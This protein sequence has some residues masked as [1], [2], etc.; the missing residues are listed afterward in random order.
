MLIRCDFCD[1]KTAVLY[2]KADTAKLCLLCDQHVHKANALSLKHVRFQIC[3]NCKNEAATIQ[4]PTD[5]LMLCQECDWDIHN[6]CSTSSLHER[7]QVE[8]FSGS[9]SIIELATFFGFDLKPKDLIAMDCRP[10]LYEHKLRDDAKEQLLEMARGNL[11]K[12]DKEG[13]EL[14]PGTPP[15]RLAQQVDVDSLELN[16]GYD[17]ELLKQ[18]TPF[19]SLLMLPTDA[20]LRKTGYASEGDLLWDCNPSYQMAQVWDFQLGKS[21]HCG[22][23][24]LL[25]FDSLKQ[26]SLVIPGTFQD[27]DNMNRMTINDDLLSRTNQSDQSSSSHVIMKEESNKKPRDE[28]SSV[29]KLMESII[30]SGTVMEHHVGGSENSNMVTTKVNTEELAKN[31]GDAML[32]Y[33]EKKKTRRYDKHIR[34]ESRKA[35]ADMRKRVRGRFVKATDATDAQV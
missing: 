34:Y 30:Y 35:R 27:I 6:N 5:T 3:D 14:G 26:D 7:S 9:P 22:E 4:C 2:C 23:P 18:Q 28:F 20:D 25:T 24:K 19:T 32:R 12:I 10:R 15:S 11:A 13:A 21:R 16:N 8:G 31:R 1:S 33:K 17:D 29:S